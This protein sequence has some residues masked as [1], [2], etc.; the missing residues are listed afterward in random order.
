MSR[1][2]MQILDR[3]LKP[4]EDKDAKQ[5]IADQSLFQKFLSIL[6]AEKVNEIADCLSSKTLHQ[7]QIK[8]FDVYQAFINDPNNRFFH[9]SRQKAY[10]KL[11]NRFF[12]LVEFTSNEFA[13]NDRQAMTL[14]LTPETENYDEKRLKLQKL[15]DEFCQK[16]IEFVQ[17]TRKYHIGLIFIAFFFLIIIPQTCSFWHF[18]AQKTTFENVGEFRLGF[19]GDKLELL[20]ADTKGLLGKIFIFQNY[21]DSITTTLS[22]ENPNIE[23][24][25]FRI[26]KGN[27]RDWLVV[28]T[29]ENS[30]TGYMKHIDTWYIANSYYQANLAVLS[31]PANGIISG[32]TDQLDQNLT[33]NI[34]KIDESD[35]EIEIE[36]VL[37]VCEAQDKCIKTTRVAHYAWRD[38]KFVLDEKRSEISALQ[39]A[40]LL[41][42]R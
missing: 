24:P 3:L 7:H 11:N 17:T 32:L 33:T 25:R 20:S 2:T 6:P 21:N 34:R 38:G 8:I 5:E 36:F 22:V 28:T 30:G 10:E 42:I 4:F 41:T 27:T 16:Y 40:N 26:V 35:D 15:T 23:S 39:I 14:H 19:N 1:E 12:A 9:S 13:P 29:I 37:E 31:Y 18:I